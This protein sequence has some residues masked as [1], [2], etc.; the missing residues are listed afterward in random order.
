MSDILEKIKAYKLDHIA[1]CKAAFPVGMIE[2]RAKAASPVRGFAQALKTAEAA[3]GYGL[4][5]EIKKA[6][7]GTTMYR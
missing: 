7:T 4:I 2:E 5:A 3:G 1:A 6:S